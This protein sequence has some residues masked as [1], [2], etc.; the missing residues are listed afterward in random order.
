MTT[1][2]DVEATS[3]NLTFKLTCIWRALLALAN[4]MSANEELAPDTFLGPG[5]EMDEDTSAAH[6]A[7]HLLGQR[8][9]VGWQ[10]R[11][12]PILPVSRSRSPLAPAFSSGSCEVSDTHSFCFLGIM[13]WC[14][15]CGGWTSGSRRQSRLNDVCGPPS[16]PPSL[17]HL[18]SQLPRHTHP[19]PSS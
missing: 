16:P 11:T 9:L 7:S 6:I 18:L 19:D 17:L 1:V 10:R 15:R 5:D 8:V 13:F 3:T 12:R 14:W 2:S 4:P